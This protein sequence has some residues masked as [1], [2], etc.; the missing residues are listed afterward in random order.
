MLTLSF[1]AYAVVMAV[2]ALLGRRLRPEWPTSRIVMRVNLPLPICVLVAA[3]IGVA[4]VGP[5]APHETDANG[6]MIAVYMT[7]GMFVAF[8]MVVLGVPASWAALRCTGSKGRPREER[9]S[10]LP[11]A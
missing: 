11:Q 3:G 5:A 9:S 2:A 8:W 10:H 1:L 4:S 7:G 6:M